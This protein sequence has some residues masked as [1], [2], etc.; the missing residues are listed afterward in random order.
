MIVDARR[1]NLHFTAPP[2]VALV[3]AE[4][5]ARIEVEMGEP[6]ENA[7][8]APIEFAL[9]TSDISD[10]F[11]RFRIDRRMSAYFCMRPVLA[12]EIGLTGAMVGGRAAGG[13]TRLVPACA[14]LPMGFTL[15]SFLWPGGR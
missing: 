10:A 1:S 6:S 14:A 11:H 8:G 7:G 9:G 4:G 5:L 13:D 12:G 2:G 15:V 3:T